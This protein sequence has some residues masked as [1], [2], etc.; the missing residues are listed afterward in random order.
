MNNKNLLNKIGYGLLGAFLMFL[1]ASVLVNFLGNLNT[2]TSEGLSF[3]VM[4]A[5]PILTILGAILGIIYT[6]RYQKNT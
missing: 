3:V 6:R 1:F 4:M 2:D 5:T